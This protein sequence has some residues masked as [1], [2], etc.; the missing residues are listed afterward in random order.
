MITATAPDTIVISKGL[1]SSV[2]NVNE[3]NV[4]N[5]TFKLILISR[6]QRAVSILLCVINEYKYESG[7][8]CSLLIY[9]KLRSV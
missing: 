7:Y 6:K 4:G 1:E 2:V 8:S 3:S 5:W 9:M